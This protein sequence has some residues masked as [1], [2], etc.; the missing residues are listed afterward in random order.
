MVQSLY[1]GKY[2]T[3]EIIMSK[4]MLVEDDTSLREIYGE[5]L[6]A[7]GFDIVSA[8]DGEE[9]LAMAVKE[10]PD[11]IISDVM[12]PR[13]SGF[14]MLDIL[15][16][17][18]EIKDTKVIMM[19]ALGQA[20]EKLRAE[21]LGADRYLVKSQVT[22]EDMTHVVY[23]VLQGTNGV[24]APTATQASEPL[25]NPAEPAADMPL[26]EEPGT[27]TPLAD[28]PLAQEPATAVAPVDMP[29][30]D[31]PQSDDATA[32]TSDAPMADDTQAVAAPVS[33]PVSVVTDEPAVEPAAAAPVADEPADSSRPDIFELLKKEVDQPTASPAMPTSEQVIQP[34]MQPTAQATSIPVTSVD[35]PAANSD[36]VAL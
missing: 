32:P 6:K 24:A 16:T 15:R 1:T 34:T 27:Q 3:G 30:T 13:I 20:E 7:E 4:I 9:A 36:Q 17:T 35:E 19:T 12:M 5:R 26:V 33:I 29:L 21:K 22:L 23:D 10:H 25:T 8:S 18:P 11:L 14:D 28:M 2:L 31:T